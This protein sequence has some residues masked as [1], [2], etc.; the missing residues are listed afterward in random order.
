MN[1][2]QKSAPLLL[3]S[4]GAAAA[5]ACLATVPLTRAQDE[6][7]E[8]KVPEKSAEI[9][10]YLIEDEHVR[11]EFG[12][13]FA[14]TPNIKKLFDEIAG[15]GKLDYEKLRRLEDAPKPPRERA[16]AALAMGALIADGFLV[17]QAE[18]VEDIEPVGR[19]LLSHAKVLGTGTRVT[20]HAKSLLEHSALEEWDTLKDELGKTQN[21][22]E[23]EMIL[24]R[25]TDVVQLIGLGGWVRGFQ[26]AAHT[27]AD[28]YSEE[29]A[30]KLKRLDIAEYYLS[31]LGD[32]EPRMRDK[33]LAANLRAGLSEIRLIIDLPEGKSPSEA[34][35]AKLAKASDTLMG[36]VDKAAGGK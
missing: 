15:L 4:V 8:K 6:G 3:R 12:I 31:I 17:V 16:A 19:G 1:P 33:T 18:R 9:P 11:E 21:D 2:I 27:A 29:K 10:S 28:R 20:R 13:N 35:A 23:A 36:H 14:T 32:M 22:V 24:L 25:D 5:F 30:A 26:I 34:D 7:E